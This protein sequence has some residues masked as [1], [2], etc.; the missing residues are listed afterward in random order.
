MGVSYS[1]AKWIA[2]VSFLI[3]FAC[4][5]Y[6]MLSSPNMKDIHDQNISF[7]SPQPFFIAAF[8]FPQQLFQLAWLYRLGKLDP[9]RPAQRAE[10]DQ[11]V[12]FVPYYALGNLCI[13]AWM[14]AWNSGRLDISHGFVT[15]NTFAQLWYM[16]T[17]LQPMNTASTSSIL[18]H[19]VSKTFAGIGV[20]DFLHNGSA[21]FFKGQP[22]NLPVKV[23]TGAGFGLASAASDWIFGGCLVYDLVALA[24]GQKGD[25][26]T[27][28]SVYA[29]GSAGIVAA[30]NIAK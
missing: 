10:L 11:I 24:V 8:F 14:V 6:G 28:L 23:L 17:K 20:L 1:T 5:N 26:R 15:I 19:I 7:F 18:T 3:D 12:D 25:W 22:A 9:S 29:T 2:P 13:A 4:Q 27:L 16:L 30:R 21:A